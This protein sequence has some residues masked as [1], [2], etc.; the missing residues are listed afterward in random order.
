MFCSALYLL[1]PCAHNHC[2]PVT[3]NLSGSLRVYCPGSPSV[4]RMWAGCGDI[5]HNVWQT[6]Q[7][8]IQ[9]NSTTPPLFSRLVCLVEVRV[10]ANKTVNIIRIEHTMV[11]FLVQSGVAAADAFQ[12]RIVWQLYVM[13]VV[14]F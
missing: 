11:T 7:N 14:G 10:V 13:P 3:A 4:L 9:C 8:I 12:L 6:C 1:R 2:E 5:F